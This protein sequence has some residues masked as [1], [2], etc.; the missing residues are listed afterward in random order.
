MEK[1]ISLSLTFL[2]Y[3]IEEVPSILKITR[4]IEGEGR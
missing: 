2:I 4:E 1:W 3:K